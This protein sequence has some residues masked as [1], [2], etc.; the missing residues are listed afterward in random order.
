M[1]TSTGSF[2]NC[3]KM[4]RVT[5]YATVLLSQCH[6]LASCAFQMP[7]QFARTSTFK[8]KFPMVCSSISTISKVQEEKDNQGMM[9]KC[10]EKRK[11]RDRVR[12]EKIK[13]IKLNHK[14]KRQKKRRERPTRTD[15]DWEQ[16]RLHR[17]AC[18]KRLSTVYQY[19]FGCL[20]VSNSYGQYSARAFFFLP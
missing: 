13:A 11:E 15:V 1:L 9:Y 10:L 4:A 17:V 2:G 12:K 3:S 5:F 8:R 18:E 19:D 16:E 20:N 14:L 6:F 7:P